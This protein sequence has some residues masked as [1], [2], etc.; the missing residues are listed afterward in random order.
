[1]RVRAQVCVFVFVRA[2]VRACVRAQ[3]CVFVCV[4]A[5]AQVFV[6]VCVC[7]RVGAC[8]CVFASMCMLSACARAHVGA[9]VRSVLPADS[10]AVFVYS[11]LDGLGCD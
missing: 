11:G 10:S 4:C 5:C 6:C 8:V 1:M 3:V 9:F 7:A 2:C